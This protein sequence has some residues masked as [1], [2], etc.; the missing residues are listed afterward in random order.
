MNELLSQL[1]FK[2][3]FI[4]HLRFIGGVVSY[5]KPSFFSTEIEMVWFQNQFESKDTLSTSE[6]ILL[7]S[8]DWIECF[9]CA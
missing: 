7:D 9:L 3:W 2:L 8:S 5:A 4:E 1:Y 6:N